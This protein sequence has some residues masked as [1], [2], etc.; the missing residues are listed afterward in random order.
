MMQ[1][2]TISS[3]LSFYRQVTEKRDG[4]SRKGREQGSRQSSKL[5]AKA[6]LIVLEACQVL[7]ETRLTVTRLI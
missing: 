7:Q 1:G 4:W 2:H 3:I 5:Q 6:D